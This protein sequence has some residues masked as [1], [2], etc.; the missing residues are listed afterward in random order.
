VPAEPAERRR[1]QAEQFGE[2]RGQPC[3]RATNA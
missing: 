1:D 3:G 2:H